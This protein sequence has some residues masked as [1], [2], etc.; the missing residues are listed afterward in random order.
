MDEYDLRIKPS[1]VKEIETI[2]RRADR[3][4]V[5]R[6]IQSLAEDARPPG[7]TRLSGREEYRIRQGAYRIIYS[8]DDEERVVLIVKVGHRKDVYR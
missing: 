8:V 5:V 3:R 6:K 4:R 7:C 1:A 2:S